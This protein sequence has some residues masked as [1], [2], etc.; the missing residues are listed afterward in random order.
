MPSN[1]AFWDRIARKY[2]A[3][4]VDDVPAYEQ[5]LESTRAHLSPED[6]VLEFGCGTGTTALKLAGAVAHITATDISPEMIAIAGEK[7][8]GG[9]PGN[10]TFAVGTLGDPAPEQPYDAVLGF[11]IL[12][13]LDDVPGAVSAIH[14]RLKPGGIFVSKTGAVG[15]ANWFLR[16]LMIPAMQLIGKA[17]YVNNLGL[18][19]IDRLI[20]DAGF[21][22]I[23][24]E[25]F[26][27]MAPTRFV[28]ARRI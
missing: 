9:V 28:V 22:I 20:A 6:K 4:P 10:V 17:P 14:A 3:K 19:E 15:E 7:L 1:A 5:T 25:T 8:A 26:P 27:G 12:H 21:E 13:L 2:A 16:T 11:N 18:E 23:E 24:T